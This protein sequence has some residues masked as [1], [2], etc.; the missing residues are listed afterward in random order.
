VTSNLMQRKVLGPV[1]HPSTSMVA[2]AMTLQG[3]IGNQ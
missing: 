1:H 3:N 2:S